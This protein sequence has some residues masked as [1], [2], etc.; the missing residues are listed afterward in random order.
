MWNWLLGAL[1]VGASIVLFGKV[2]GRELALKD[3]LLSDGSPFKPDPLAVWHLVD[4]LK[5]TVFGTSA[6]YI[7]TLAEND[8]KPM[9]SCSLSSLHSIYSTGSPLSP[10]SFDYVY[11]DIKTDVLLGSVTGGT[12][13]LKMEKE[14]K[15][16]VF[17]FFFASDIVSLFAGANAALPVYRGEI[18]CRNLGMSVESWT[19]QGDNVEGEEGDLVCTKAFPCM[20]VFFWNDADGSKYKKA[21]FSQF[22]GVWYHGDFLDINPHTGGIVML[23]RR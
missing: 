4:E 6:K 16:I 14:K 9:A 3:F 13:I 12:G 15:I 19:L 18:Q 2:L 7:A 20:P 10:E 1:S 17:F 22:P 21:Y 23:G 5:I 11:R 8:V